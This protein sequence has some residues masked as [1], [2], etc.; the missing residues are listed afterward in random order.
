MK[1]TGRSHVPRGVP[2]RIAAVQHKETSL[3]KDKIMRYFEGATT[4]LFAVA[5]QSLALGLLFAL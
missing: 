4:M 1:L 5:A 2:H 3:R